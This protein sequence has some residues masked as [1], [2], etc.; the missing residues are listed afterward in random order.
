MARERRFMLLV[1]DTPEV[2]KTKSAS[3]AGGMLHLPHFP[4]R[5]AMKRLRF[6]FGMKHS[7]RCVEYEASR[8][9]SKDMLLLAPRF[10]W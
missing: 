9:A 8:F 6:R 4:L 2:C 5:L 7:P 10:A 1:L 3:Y